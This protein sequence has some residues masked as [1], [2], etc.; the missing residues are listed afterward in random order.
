MSTSSQAFCPTSAAH[1]SPVCVVEVETPGIPETVGPDLGPDPASLAR[2]RV[3]GRHRVAALR[4]ERRDVDAEDA[5]QQGRP[6]LPVPV[7]VVRA[8]PIAE[9]DVQV[10]VRPENEMAPVVVAV[11]LRDDQDLSLAGSVGPVRVAGVD[12]EPRYDGAP[13]VRGRVVDV[14]VAVRLVRRVE[15]QPEQPLL[16]APV[17][18]PFPDVHER[19]DLRGVRPVFEEDDLARLQHH[20]Q[21]VVGLR[22]VGEVDHA[23]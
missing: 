14:E 22:R 23:L 13:G 6:V 2:E 4:V 7:G 11:R 15:G 5:P 9:A 19:A 10:P 1:R 21:P 12:R 18:D 20:E 3:V 8:S 17:A 16:V